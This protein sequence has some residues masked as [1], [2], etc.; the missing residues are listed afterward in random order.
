VEQTGYRRGLPLRLIAKPFLGV[1]DFRGRSQRTEIIGYYLGFMLLQLL[2][3]IIGEAA[4]AAGL[5]GRFSPDSDV[6][7]AL[8]AIFSAPLVALMFRRLQDM[9]SNG[10]LSVPVTLG[11]LGLYQWHMHLAPFGEAVPYPDWGE[12][13]R[14]LF[15]LCVFAIILA[16]GNHGPNRYGP[17]P[18]DPSEPVRSAVA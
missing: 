10:W 12:Y 4:Q 11:A 17:D 1:C 5:V 16:P 18:R 6:S 15:V 8:S 14:I 7:V 13:V 2:I 3:S 9:G